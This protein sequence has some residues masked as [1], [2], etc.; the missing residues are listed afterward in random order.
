MLSRRVPPHLRLIAALAVASL[1]APLALVAAEA[2]SAKN[3]PAAKEKSAAPAKKKA[4]P[5]A[6]PKPAAK[7]TYLQMTDVPYPPVLRGDKPIVTD[8]SP[9]FLKRPPTISS[10]V[11]VAKTPPTIDFGFYPGQ[12]WPG[13]PWSNWGDSLAVG[14]KYYASIGDHLWPGGNAYLYEYDPA[15]KT[16]RK[17]FEVKE[18]LKVPEGQYTPGKVHSRLDMGRDGKIY[19]S[20]HRGAPKAAADAYGYKGDCIFR[21]DPKTGTTE[22]VVEGAV[23]KHSI[24]TSVLDPERLIFYGGTAQGMDSKIDGVQFLAYDC[25]NKKMLQTNADGPPRY[26]MFARST[27]RVYYVPASNDAGRLVRFDPAVGGAPQPIDAVLGVRAATEETPDGKIYTASTGQGKVGE[28]MLWAFDVKTEKV[29]PLGNGAVGEQSYIASMDADPTGRYVYYIPGAHGG[30]E[31][32]GSAVV[33]FD[34]ETRRKKVIAFLHPFY[35]EKYG[36]A[37]K[38]T[39]STAV[40]PKGEKLYVTWNAGRGT[41]AWDCCAITVIHIPES[42]RRP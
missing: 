5:A 18:T 32:D 38:G 23:P 24:P 9:D 31:K 3:K 8:N 4:A 30:S 33:Q 11:D 28:A 10:E 19:F 37:L 40:D 29:E 16:F 42:E 25:A 34:T 13:N 6:K 41:R 26:L 14:D 22:I 2:Q 27:G 35:Q 39:Y 15:A 20:T 21:C 17:I 12:N 7:P 36:V 1:L